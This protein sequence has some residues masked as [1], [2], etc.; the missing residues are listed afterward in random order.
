MQS[1]QKDQRW[2]PRPVVGNPPKTGGKDKG[3]P[4]EYFQF[5]K[6]TLKQYDNTEQHDND[7]DYE[8]WV[9]LANQLTAMSIKV[10]SGVAYDL[11]QTQI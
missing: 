4:L 10:S 2:T 7:H 5:R 3:Y 8:C 6:A 9:Y 11:N 1:A